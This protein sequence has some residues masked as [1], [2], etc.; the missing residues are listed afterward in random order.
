MADKI[1]YRMENLQNE[2]DGWFENLTHKQEKLIAKM[3]ESELLNKLNSYEQVVHSFSKFFDTDELAAVLERKADMELVRRLR[4]NKAEI[5]DV[6]L[7]Q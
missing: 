2:L 1:K 4:D 3:V 6:E 5:N 7:M